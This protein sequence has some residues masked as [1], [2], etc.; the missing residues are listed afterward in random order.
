[1]VE[2]KQTTDVHP[3][4]AV[5]EAIRTVL[6]E[7]AR[8]LV[9]ENPRETT[10]A[11]SSST[12]GTSESSSLLLDQ[13]LA[14]DVLMKEPGYPPYRASIMDGYCI[15]SEETFPLDS[16]AETTAPTATHRVVDKIFAGDGR[17]N[18]NNVVV[19]ATT[20]EEE[21]RLPSAYY[22]TTGAMVPDFFDCVVPI[23]DVVTIA[24]NGKQQQDDSPKTIAICKLPTTMGKWIRPVGCD[25]SPGSVVLPAGHVIDPVSLGLLKQSGVATVEIRPKVAVGV[26]STG[27]ELVVDGTW[28]LTT[29]GAMQGKI[30][31]VNRPILCNLLQELGNCQVHDM[32]TCRDDDPVAM[33]NV[34]RKA[35]EICE[36]IVTTGGISMGESDIVEQVLVQELGG[37]LHFGR[38]HM[39]PGKPS[40]FVTIPRA[41][42]NLS[43]SSTRFV[44]ALPGNPVSGVVCAHLLVRP[45]LQL[46][47]EG[48]DEYSTDIHRDSSTEETIRRIVK[49]ASLDPPEVLA[50]L[51]HDIPLDTERPEYHRVMLKFD[52]TRNSWIATSTGVQRSSRL[53][54]LRDANALLALPQA[55]PHK[56]KALA[57]EHF[58]AL[59]LKT[60]L[61]PK[62]IVSQSQHLNQQ[63]IPKILFRVNIVQLGGFIAEKVEERVK[64]ALSG[65]KSGSI[66]INS[67]RMFEGKPEDLYNF[68][69]KSDGQAADF[70]IIVGS[71]QKGSFASNTAASTCLR[72]RLSKVA[73]AIALQ[74][75]LGAAAE[76]PTA[77][78]FETV[79]GLIEREPKSLLAFIPPEGLDGGLSSVRGIL[80]HALEV[81]RGT[82]HKH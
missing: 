51:A 39:K 16:F 19:A 47:Y 71:S 80:K 50:Q 72:S 30:P 36:V 38:I 57:G 10:T 25:I 61:V 64:H 18:N 53:M 63:P 31:D 46:L 29:D 77:A 27:N 9:D 43:S 20:T 8:R 65:S 45:C 68:L 67:T 79:V 56:A 37:T 23:E 26:L 24:G 1:M 74:L 82:N 35:L 62:I 49:S 81:A 33:A 12:I 75:R 3:M 52:A 59:L 40:T 21:T 11:V 70:Y 34:I 44:F 55:T 13:V 41:A 7:T 66:M 14:K 17:K 28:D 73:D 58:P 15:R 54:S 2:H 5:P 4:V 76:S 78:L 42:T 22:V 69:V 48:I 6:V 32:G 60:D